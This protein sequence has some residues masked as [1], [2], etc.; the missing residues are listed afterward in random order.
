MSR[1]DYVIVG[2]GTAGSILANRL[3][4]DGRFRV[5][6][7]EA[8]GTPKSPWIKIPAGFSKLLTNTTYNWC[9]ESKPE[10]TTNERVIAIPRG[11]GLGGSTLINGMIYVRGQP[12]DYDSWLDDGAIG[13]GW[14][15][16]EPYFG[17]LENF[18]EGGPSRGKSGP[19]YLTRVSE[20]FAISDAFLKAAAEDGQ[21]YNDDYNGPQQEGVGYYQV[22]Q[23]DGRRW[24]VVDGY[25]RP[26]LARSNLTVLTGCRVHR[27]ELDGNRCTGVTYERAGKSVTVGAEQEVVLC[28]GAIQNPQLLEL[29]GIGNPDI[30]AKAGIKSKVSLAG[31]GENYIDHYATRMNWRVRNTVTLNEMSRGW[32]LGQELLKYIAGRKGILTLGTGLVHAFI[33]TRHTLSRPDVQFFFVHASYSNAATR[34]LDR[35]PGMTIGVTQ[36]RPTSTGSIH[37]VNGN[38][39][40]PPSIKPNMLSTE[41]DCRVL[42]EG[43]KAARKIVEQPALRDFVDHEMAPGKEVTT[44]EQWLAFARQNGQ[45]I[46][47][48][49]GTCK[50]GTD[51]TAVVSPDLQVKGVKGLSVADASVMPSMVSGNTQGAVMMVAEK[52]ADIIIERAVVEKCS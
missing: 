1:Y 9:F 25:L 13:W 46:Y 47:H 10:A 24:S 22:T 28:A 26:A 37:V 50:M 42:V 41:E 38:V 15:D 33:K 6:L 14:R 21:P 48:P 35:K 2:G 11:K 52:A 19:M 7:L 44:D 12:E 20:R 31:V 8:G 23:R 43:M 5:L 34:I 29:S 40:T 45:T 51:E 16:V 32:R 36:L 3:T 30:L 4:A 17:K 18:A 39:E 27:L 49:I